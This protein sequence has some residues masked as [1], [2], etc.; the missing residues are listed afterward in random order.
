[1]STP[2]ADVMADT[3]DA[4]EDVMVTMADAK[5]AVADMR[6]ESAAGTEMVIA[7]ADVTKRLSTY[8]T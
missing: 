7:N 2:A 4:A 5:A 6:M 3:E 8:W 1:M